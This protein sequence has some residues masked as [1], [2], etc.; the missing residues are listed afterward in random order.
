MLVA[1]GCSG[2]HSTDETNNAPV[3]LPPQPGAATAPDPGKPAAS[4]TS[5]GTTASKPAV[6]VSSDQS[7]LPMA[8]GNEWIYDAEQDEKDTGKDG[9]NAKALETW[10]EEH[11]TKRMAEGDASLEEG[12]VFGAREAYAEVSKRW[13]PKADCVKAARDKLADLQKDKDAKKALGQEKMFTQAQALED[14]GDKANAAA[15]YDK[16]AKAAAGTKF[17]DYCAK[18]VKELR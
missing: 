7:Y 2:A 14:S 5:P 6:V 3:A 17:A 18:K 10:V 8:E 11:G 16:C 4:S 12:D 13:G 9:D 1:W 15:A